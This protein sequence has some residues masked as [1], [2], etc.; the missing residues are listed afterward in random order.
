[1]KGIQCRFLVSCFVIFLGYAT[2]LTF[3]KVA[4]VEDG[5]YILVGRDKSWKQIATADDSI[6]CV[7][8]TTPILIIEYITVEFPAL[9]RRHSGLDSLRINTVNIV[10]ISV[11]G[12]DVPSNS[13]EIDLL[14]DTTVIEIP[15]Y[16]EKALK[17]GI[18]GRVIISTTIDTVGRP[19]N[20][21]VLRSSGNQ[22]LD[23]TAS[24]MVSNA[25]YGLVTLD[26][27]KVRAILFIP[28]KFKLVRVEE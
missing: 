26:R 4:F 15:D 28:I 17:P 9:I 10:P 27:R 25:K 18:E 16:P 13:M 3:G 20:T 21:Y 8:E 19:S 22:A 6:T 2:A 24:D 5:S 11:F 7:I 23:K 1:M 14:V 12:R